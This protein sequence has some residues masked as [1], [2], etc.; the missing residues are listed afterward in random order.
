MSRNPECC[1]L[2]HEALEFFEPVV[3]DDKVGV[4]REIL[5]NSRRKNLFVNCPDSE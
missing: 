2:R 4:E 1:L 5:K 3:N